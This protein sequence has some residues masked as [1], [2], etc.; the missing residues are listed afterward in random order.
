MKVRLKLF[1]S[2]HDLLPPGASLNGMDIEVPDDATP[3]QIIDRFH[4]PHAEAHLVL[5]NSVYLDPETRDRPVLHDGDVLA[6][7]PPIA[8][9]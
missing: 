6:V 2:L 5:H 8:G 7:W 9:G 4:V 1:A 3:H